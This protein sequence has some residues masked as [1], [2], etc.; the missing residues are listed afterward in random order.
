[1]GCGCGKTR[2]YLVTTKDGKEQTV[3]TL[4]AAMTIIRRE[5]GRYQPIKAAR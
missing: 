4:N 1:M 3:D 5:G 2:K